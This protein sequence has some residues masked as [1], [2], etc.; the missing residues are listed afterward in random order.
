[1][2]IESERSTFQ[3]GA[4]YCEEK[5]S[6]PLMRPGIEKAKIKRKTSTATLHD[7]AWLRGAMAAVLCL[8]VATA[9]AGMD[10]QKTVTEKL[11]HNIEF[12]SQASPKKTEELKKLILAVAEAQGSP[13]HSL[14]CPLVVQVRHSD[15]VAG[16]NSQVDEETRGRTVRVGTHMHTHGRVAI[17]AGGEFA[18]LQDYGILIEIFDN[19]NISAQ[20][21]I[22]T[23]IHEAEYHVLQLL[24]VVMQARSKPP[25]D[26]ATL[27]SNTLAEENKNRWKA[28]YDVER[29]KAYI[30]RTVWLA[31]TQKD[32]VPGLPTE[33]ETLATRLLDDAQIQF[34]TAVCQMNHLPSGPPVDHKETTQQVEAIGQAWASARRRIITPA[35]T[36][37]QARVPVPE[38]EAPKC[39]APLTD[40]QSQ[41]VLAYVRKQA[42]RAEKPQGPKAQTS[43]VA[44]LRKGLQ[45]LY[46]KA[47]VTNADVRSALKH[48]DLRSDL[49]ERAKKN[50]I[51]D[52]GKVSEFIRS[53]IG[54]DYN[55]I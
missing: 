7:Q 46:P 16:G 55:D 31:T 47:D 12:I 24:P 39:K 25:A 10:T 34:E 4:R 5:S 14:T 13:L 18:E 52:P 48:K 45:K 50:G 19:E 42:I 40:Q 28:H 30:E 20:D 2:P 23:F 27:F 22:F 17:Q 32:K 33:V 54:S 11:G 9:A 51:T 53:F 21:L 29:C 41:D 8:G 37:V 43:W 35:A 26:A 36:P 49:A 38:H 3:E 1:M 44:Q 6:K 15:E